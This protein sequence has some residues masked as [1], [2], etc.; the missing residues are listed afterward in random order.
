MH[1]AST[2]TRAKRSLLASPRGCLVACAGCDLRKTHNRITCTLA[3][4]SLSHATAPPTEL[5]TTAGRSLST[6]HARE[7]TPKALEVGAGTRTVMAL[8]VIAPKEAVIDTEVATD[9]EVAIDTVAAGVA[10]IEATTAVTSGDT[11]IV[12][13]TVT[14]TVTVIVVEATAT[15]IVAIGMMTA[16]I[17]I[18]TVTAT[19]TARGIGSIGIGSIEIG[20]LSRNK[21]AERE[22]QA[23]A[24][25]WYR[26]QA[27]SRARSAEGPGVRVWTW[28][29]GWVQ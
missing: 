24:V 29:V 20:S 19:A 16:V 7:T 13:V 6:L 21:A 5:S 26:V 8:V 15:A 17:V 3:H 14:V 25:M 27:R 11:T 2:V 18:V 10:T 4:A 22:P 28:V 1:G 12:T 9:T 23:Q